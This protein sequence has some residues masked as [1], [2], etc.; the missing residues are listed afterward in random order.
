MGRFFDARSDEFRE[1]Y[2]EEAFIADL[3]Q[4]IHLLMEQKG[5]S[6]AEL[7]RRI[8]VS[9]AYVTQMLGNKPQNLTARTIAR[10]YVALGEEPC[11]RTKSEPHHVGGVDGTWVDVAATAHGSWMVAYEEAELQPT[12]VAPSL[13]SESEWVKRYMPKEMA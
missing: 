8:G 3:Q 4:A 11:I 13:P 5:V 2:A 6:R 12:V 9:G 10:V 1:L 7:A